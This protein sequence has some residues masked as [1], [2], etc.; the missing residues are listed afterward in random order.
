MPSATHLTSAWDEVDRTS[1]TTASISPTASRWLVVDCYARDDG[2]VAIA[3][4]I[5]GLSGGTALSWTT[6]HTK[7]DAGTHHQVTRFYAWTTGSP[8]SGT[9]G[10]SFGAT[11]YDGCGWII[12]EL[13]SD[14]DTSDPFVQTASNEGGTTSISVTLAA[15]GSSDNRPLVCAFH[16]ANEGATQEAGYTEIADIFGAN[17]IMGFA[18]AYNPTATDTNPNYTWVTSSSPNLAIAS[19]IKVSAGGGAPAVA[20]RML[21]GV[22][23]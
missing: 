17:P 21:L 18:A 12:Y 16:R 14:V 23:T 19:E 9:I 5:S 7:V 10:F 13:S 11:T 2:T 20:R 15:F 22:G 6:E 3:P 8:V 4:T 1:Y